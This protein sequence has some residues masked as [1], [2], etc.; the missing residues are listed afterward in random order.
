MPAKETLMK[1]QI[2]DLVQGDLVDLERDPYADPK[3]EDQSAHFEFAVVDKL[4]IETPTCTVVHFENFG[5]V[6]FPPD[7][8]VDVGEEKPEPI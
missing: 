7:H 2:K 1:K 6:G 8:E 5:S 3:G 4:E